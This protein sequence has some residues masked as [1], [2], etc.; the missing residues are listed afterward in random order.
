M[1]RKCKK[2]NILRIVHIS[3]AEN[4][5]CFFSENIYKFIF[6]LKKMCFLDRKHYYMKKI[7]FLQQNAEV[8]DQKF[9]FGVN[10]VFFT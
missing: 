3:L 7:R 4:K 2:L 9:A 10:A 6:N 8:P 5:K 1:A